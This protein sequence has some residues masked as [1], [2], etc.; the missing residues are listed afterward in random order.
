MRKRR[1]RR[2]KRSIKKITFSKSRIKMRRKKKVEKEEEKEERKTWKIRIRKY[3]M[4]RKIRRNK[5]A[6]E[7][8]KKTRIFILQ[9][10]E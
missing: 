7:Q 10:T 6:E 3:S 5:R 1:G 9:H 4:R 2:S 8:I